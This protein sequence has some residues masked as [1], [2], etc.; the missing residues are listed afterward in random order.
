M[1][2]SA[3]DP[4][5]QLS[6][7]PRAGLRE[8][9]FRKICTNGFGDGYN[10]YAYSMAWFDEYVYIGTSRAN[11]H[12]LK[13]GMPFVHI[14]VWPVECLHKNYSPEFEHGPARG[15]IWKYHPPTVKWSRVFRSPLVVDVEGVEYSRDLG[16]RA[17][18]VYKGASDSRPALYTTTWSRSRSNGPEILQCVDG[19]NFEVMPTPH[20]TSTIKDVTITS[21][22]SLVSFKGRLFTAPTGGSHGHVNGAGNSLIYCTE[23]PASGSWISVNDPGFGQF[24]EVAAVYELAVVDNYLY[25]GTSGL[26]GFQIWKTD[27]EGKLPFQMGKSAQCGRRSRCLEPVCSCHDRFRR[28]AL[29]RHRYSKRRL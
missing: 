7:E 11:L 8:K 3:L 18:I 27:A 23:D 10:A 29:H 12:L 26:S 21:I 22:R 28:S 15:E 17:M 24:P 6:P 13:M 4:S 2:I 19:E 1:S 16:F 25:A 9:D 20:F 14:D 5:L